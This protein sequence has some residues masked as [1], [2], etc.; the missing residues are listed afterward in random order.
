MSISSKLWFS[1]SHEWMWEL[2]RK[3]GWRLLGEL[4]I[5]Q[6]VQDTGLQVRALVIHSSS[7]LSPLL[8]PHLTSSTVPRPPDR[9]TATQDM[10]HA[11][12]VFSHNV[13]T[14]RS[15]KAVRRKWS[16]NTLC[17]IV[18]ENNYLRGWSEM[19]GRLLWYSCC[20]SLTF[21]L[22]IPCP[23]RAKQACPHSSHFPSSL[24]HPSLSQLPSPNRPHQ[25]RRGWNHIGQHHT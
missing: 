25:W 3:E 9:W 15:A 22:P 8:T 19:P 21:C 2:D 1:S 14:R 5:I 24:F 11:C 12:S 4:I 18:F 17:Q 16:Q 20:W 10:A 7:A 23:S 13:A 6:G